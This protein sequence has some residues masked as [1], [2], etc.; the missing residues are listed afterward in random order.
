[1]RGPAEHRPVRGAETDVPVGMFGIGDARL[2]EELRAHLR[3][4]PPGQMC[5][6]DIE[7]AIDDVDIDL[8]DG[9]DPH[10]LDVD[11]RSVEHGYRERRCKHSPNGR[12]QIRPQVEY[13]LG[14]TGVDGLRP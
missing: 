12:T 10:P 3:G 7:R 8:S 6:T 11:C 2:G 4:D 13:V 14:A 1:M 9:E 5:P